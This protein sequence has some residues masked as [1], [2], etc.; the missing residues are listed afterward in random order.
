ME[1]SDE[2][3]F[4]ETDEPFDQAR[5]ARRERRERT[6]RTLRTPRTG[7]RRVTIGLKQK[8]AVERAAAVTDNVLNMIDTFDRPGSAYAT[9]AY[10]DADAFAKPGFENKP[11]ERVPKAGAYAAVGVGLARAEW[12]VCD[13]TVKGPNTSAI[14][15]ASVTGV[16]AFVNAELASSSATA[17]PLH[18]KAGLGVETGFSIGAQ[19]VEVKLLGT[20]VSIGPKMG[21]SVLGNEL[22]L[23][24]A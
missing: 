16:K 17:G 8:S 20:G 3:D 14:A 4:R 24:L 15:Q 21:I 10:A 11:M 13:I 5:R 18:A 9:L 19:G 2:E 12:S 1:W 7:R 6:E 22:S 23:E